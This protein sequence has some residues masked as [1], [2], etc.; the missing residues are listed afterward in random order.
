MK[1]AVVTA[2]GFGDGLMMSVASE[3][4]RKKGDDITTFNNH[5]S[6]LSDWFPHHQFELPTLE[7][8][9]FDLI[10]LQHDNS[11]KSA[12]IIEKYRD[13]LSIF[14]PYYDKNR[15]APFTKNDYVLDNEKPLVCE[16]ARAVN[17]LFGLE[18][19]ID[20]GLQIPNDLRIEK[21]RGRVAIHPSS[22]DQ[23]RT[24][25]LKKFV[26]VARWLTNRGFS[27]FFC[28]SPKERELLKPQLPKWIEVPEVSSLDEVAKLIAES[29]FVIGN[30]SG[31]VHLAS[32]LDLPFIVVASRMRQMRQ[33]Q[34][35]WRIGTIVTP[36]SW[37]P[38]VKGF[39]FRE[40]YWQSFI[41]SYFVTQAIKNTIFRS[42]I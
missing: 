39:R 3:Q 40:K 4:F 41:P 11:E 17:S 24:W 10:I 38:N 34:P 37:V 26:Q 7:L 16:I 6:Q 21:K 14:Y 12:K 33:W 32:N 2:D 25:T 36:P 28:L 22:S 18:Y 19:N 23:S 13:K 27:P 8:D 29:H 42:S 31:I 30:E 1:I 35:G 20:N 9:R 5:L 15:H